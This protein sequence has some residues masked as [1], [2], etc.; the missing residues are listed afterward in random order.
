MTRALILAA[1]EGTRLRP[2]TNDRPKCLVPLV[3]ETILSRQARCYRRLGIEKIHVVT[4][5]R[6]DQVEALGFETTVNT[7]FDSTNM[8][9]SL[10]KATNFIEG[11]GDLIIS[12]GD[13]VFEDENLKSLMKSEGPISL[14][15]DMEWEK[16][17]RKRF[18]DPLE[19]AETLK[20]GSNGRIIEVGKKPKDIGEIE[21]QYT[22]LIKIAGDAIPNLIDFYNRVDKGMTF[23][24]KDFRNMY[25]TSFLQL[26]I[27]G[28]W[29]V[30]SVPVTGGWLEVDSVTDLET[31]EHLFEE[32]T[33]KDFC[34]LETLI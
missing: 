26:L 15:I 30:G 19:D 24:G 18:T 3:G 17:W 29:D 16:L 32:G 28:G 14:M 4:G 1:G 31:Y 12:Y 22:S 33:L 21:G 27:D 23:D 9:T 10:F 7:E 6:S 20:L 25:M 5:Y 13:I 11:G 8:V 2:I 34:R